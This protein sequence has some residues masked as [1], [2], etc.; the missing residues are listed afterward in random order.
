MFTRRFALCAVA[1]AFLGTP[2]ARAQ[3]PGAADEKSLRDVLRAYQKAWNSHDVN[4]WSS[5]LA[6]DIWFTEAWD[7]YG[8]QKGR[9]NAVNLFK[10]NFAASELKLDVVRMRIMP[11]GTA[12]I[13]MREIVSHLPKTAGKYKAV[14]ESDPVIS[15]WRK[16]GAAWK[17]FFFTSDKGWALDQ[18]KKDGLG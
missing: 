2:S 18:L 8:R 11:D 17:M 14:F 9:E 5:F 12:T 7:S 3:Q 1:V 13:A 15:R 4:A 6:D 16:E 10:S